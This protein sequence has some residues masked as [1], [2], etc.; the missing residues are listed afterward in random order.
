MESANELIEQCFKSK[1]GVKTRLKKPEFVSKMMARMAEA[2]IILINRHI[3]NMTPTQRKRAEQ[4]KAGTYRGK[5][6]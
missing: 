2:Q 6:V 1:A 3:P 5:R 4:V